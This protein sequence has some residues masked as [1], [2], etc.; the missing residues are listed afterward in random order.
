MRKVCI[1]VYFII[2]FHKIYTNLLYIVKIY[3]NLYQDN[4]HGTF[5]MREM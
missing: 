2:Y 5:A 1:D 4:I 3:P